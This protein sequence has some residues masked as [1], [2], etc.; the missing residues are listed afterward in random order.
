M[1]KYRY[2]FLILLTAIVSGLYLVSCG[3]DSDGDGDGEGGDD[4]NPTSQIV[5]TW[6]RVDDDEDKD[7]IMYCANGI[8][9]YFGEESSS[10]FDVEKFEYIYNAKSGKITYISDDGDTWADEV[11]AVSNT[12]LILKCS[13]GSDLY[14]EVYKKTTTSYTASQLEKLYQKLQSSGSY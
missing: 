10:G 8:G 1:K 2:L 12:K 6:E 7:Y 9:Y 14:T 4:G 3:S 13:S 11:Q 5:G